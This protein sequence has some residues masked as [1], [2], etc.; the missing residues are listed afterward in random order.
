MRNLVRFFVD[1]HVLTIS[2]FGAVMLFGAI[3]ALDRGVDLMPSI[4][5]PI[6]AVVTSYPGAGPEEV[7]REVS[8]PIE[9]ALATLGGVTAITST[10]AENM[11]SVV[12]QFS[13]DSDLDSSAV[14]VSQR[15]NALLASLPDDVGTPAIQKFDPADEPILSVALYAPGI[16]LAEIQKHAEDVL[17]PALLRG[18]GV[19]SVD[20]TGP[21]SHE[22]HILLDQGQLETYG[23]SASQVAGAVQGSTADVPAGHLTLEDSR[24]LL[25]GRGAPADLS[26][27]ADIRVDP[28]RGIRVSD[29]AVVRDARAEVN[30]Y[31]RY[32]GESVI[33]LD[34]RKSQGAN[35][36]AT[37]SDVRTMLAD[38]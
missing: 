6:V 10:S 26:E 30:S 20:V 21:A 17:A 7:S 11:S 32:N 35:T 27:V 3:A 36:V 33:L 1:N 15:V 14:E 31:A 37:A 4:D 34:I 12:V 24:L 9:D 38:Q 25:T 29:V 2:I 5:V 19:A 22:V 8:E 16:D 13:A 23:I 18:D 28:V